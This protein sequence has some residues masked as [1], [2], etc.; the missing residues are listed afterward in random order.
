[1]SGVI[2]DRGLMQVHCNA[3]GAGV[4]RMSRS[5]ATERVDRG[6]REG[7]TSPGCTAMPMNARPE[8][9]HRTGRLEARTPMQRMAGVDEMARTAMFPAGDASSCCPGHDLPVDGGGCR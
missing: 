7:S 5:M 8:M 2:V 6:V 9:V 4:I 3:S 1:M